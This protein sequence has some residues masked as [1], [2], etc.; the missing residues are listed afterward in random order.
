LFSAS[1][2]FDQVVSKFKKIQLFNATDD[3]FEMES[4]LKNWFKYLKS[5]III[6]L[7]LKFISAN[8]DFQCELPCVALSSITELDLKS[9]SV[10]QYHDGSVHPQIQCIDGDICDD[11]S[12]VYEVVCF[13]NGLT[14][15]GEVDWSCEVDVPDDLMVTAVY[16]LCEGYRNENDRNYAYVNSCVAKV[17][18]IK[19]S[20]GLPMLQDYAGDFVILF[21]FVLICMGSCYYFGLRRRRGQ[22]F[23][24]INAHA[25]IVT[26]PYYQQ[27]QNITI[28]DEHGYGQGQPQNVTIIEERGRGR[29]L[30]APRNFTP[31]EERGRKRSLSGSRNDAPVGA[32]Y[33]SQG[34]NSL[35]SPSTPRNVQHQ[36]KPALSDYSPADSHYAINMSSNQESNGIFGGWFSPKSSNANSSD[37]HDRS[38]EFR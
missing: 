5:F 20:S 33:G 4:Y 15:R 35:F 11:I 37:H 21:L 24:V 10:S 27:Q 29:T 34:N 13:N 9:G 16:P 36:A 22:V 23:E 3:L 32:Y 18:V 1:T 17:S 31:I 30:S 26:K 14:G 8:D 28:I 19:T 6:L 25:S 38:N 12:E 2:F 7:L